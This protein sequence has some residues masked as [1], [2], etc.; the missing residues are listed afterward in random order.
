MIYYVISDIHAHYDAMISSLKQKNFNPDNHHL[1]VLGDLFDR[2]NQTIAVLEYL[3]PLS[4]ANK[5]TIILGNHDAFLL[6][7]LKGDNSKVMFN[8]YYNGFGETLTSLSGIKESQN[9]IDEIREII[10]KRYPYLKEWLDSFPFYLEKDKYIFVHGGIDGSIR[11]WPK[12]L[13][14]DDFIWSYEDE[15]PPVPGKIVVAGHKRIPTIKYKNVDYRK[16]FKRNPEAFDILYLDNK[17]LIDRFVEVSNEINV[18][19]LEINNMRK[20]ND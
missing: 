8:V 9:N 3:Y 18:L 6:D 16:L 14:R 12:V 20:T 11:N 5:A 7:F 17:I 19:I 13:T 1:I 2:G 10:K 15:L 4:K